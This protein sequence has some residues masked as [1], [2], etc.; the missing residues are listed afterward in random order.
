MKATPGNASGAP[1]T[2]TGT[3]ST[4]GSQTYTVQ[5]GDSLSKIAKQFYDSE[6]QTYIKLIQDANNIKDA[7]VIQPGDVLKIPPKP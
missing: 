5:A 4:G 3:V 2:A 1:G 6:A 7:S